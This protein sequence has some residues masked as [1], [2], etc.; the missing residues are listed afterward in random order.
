MILS[1]T[2]SWPFSHTL[3]TGRLDIRIENVKQ[4]S[5]VSRAGAACMIGWRTARQRY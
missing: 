1:M 4:F 3:L 5:E 2:R